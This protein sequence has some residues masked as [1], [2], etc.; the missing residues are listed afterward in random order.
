MGTPAPRGLSL[1]TSACDRQP[2]RLASESSI[3]GDLRH[4]GE[5]R[6]S[7][8][9]D[10]CLLVAGS[11][12]YPRSGEGRPGGEADP[13]SAGASQRGLAR[14]TKTLIHDSHKTDI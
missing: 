7:G 3:T 13:G 5:C 1:L 12:A 10:K 11:C 6:D 4:S 2:Q 14:S 8:A 9:R